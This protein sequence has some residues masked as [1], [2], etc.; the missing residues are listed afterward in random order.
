M[1]GGVR[2]SDVA[3]RLWHGDVTLACIGSECAGVLLLAKC[4]NAGKSC[5]EDGLR[6]L[7][8][9]RFVSGSTQPTN[10]STAVDEVDLQ[11]L[12]TTQ[13]QQVVDQP[14]DSAWR[15]SKRFL[16]TLGQMSRLYLD[17]LRITAELAMVDQSA[18]SSSSPAPTSN[19]T[20][21]WLSG[22]QTVTARFTMAIRDL[23]TSDRSIL[24]ALDQAR[25]HPGHLFELAFEFKVVPLRQEISS[26]R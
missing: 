7:E 22:N 4:G 17:K 16:H 9:D 18:I 14:D 19:W 1:T 13:I 2:P 5:A 15:R 10:E 25:K 26:R 20:S 23:L 3:G 12:E 11:L 21:P 6:N 8:R 24:Q